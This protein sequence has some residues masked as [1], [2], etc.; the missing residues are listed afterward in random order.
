MTK[1]IPMTIEKF[2]RLLPR[3]KK[4]NPF[5]TVSNSIRFGRG[6]GGSIKIDCP[7]S[8]VYLVKTGDRIS[9]KPADLR[10]AF[11]FRP[12]RRRPTG[13]YADAVGMI[14]S[15]ADDNG[16]FGYESR[17]TTRLRRRMIKV[18]DLGRKASH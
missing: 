17:F 6:V 10:K 1:P 11:A 2:F 8:A 3:T 18:L 9:M 14:M 12:D 15:A 16:A 7:L 5:L 13:L 4:L